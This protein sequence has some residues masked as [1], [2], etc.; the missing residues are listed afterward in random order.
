MKKI[1]CLFMFVLVSL[2]LFGCANSEN[3]VVRDMSLVVNPSVEYVV[4]GLSQVDSVI[5]VEVDPDGC[6]DED[7]IAS[8]FFTSDLV[9]E[10]HYDKNDS[11]V[12][13]GTKAGGSIDIFETEEEAI[14]R[15]EYL[16]KF[17]GKWIFDSGS[18]RVVGTIVIRTSNKL[19]DDVQDELTENI[20]DSLTL[21]D[22]TEDM[23]AA[24]KQEIEKENYEKEKIKV[25]KKYSD[26]INIKYKDAAKFMEKVGF[27]N[28]VTSTESIEYDAEKEGKTVEI[29]IGGN[30]DFKSDDK[31]HPSEEVKI[32]YYKGKKVEVPENWFDLVELHY[33]EVKNKLS[34]AGFTNIVLQAHE[35]DYDASKVFEGSVINIS[36]DD[37]ATFEK[38]DKFYTNVKIRIDYRV[39]LA[40]KEVPP[41]LSND[42][43]QNTTNNA[44]SN[45]NN[46]SNWGNGTNSGN[47][48]TVPQPEQGPILVWVP[49]NGG[50]KYHSYSSCSNMKNPIQVTEDTAKANGFTACA[51]CH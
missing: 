11:I 39:K 22:I 27:T 49:T 34:D 47:S 24:T 26:L 12:E 25:G 46:S 3:E 9:D 31:F 16:Q 38:G 23:V 50:K 36:I 37:N 35:V 28:I 29:T 48:V 33:D 19:E 43:Q 13:R 14:E 20:I 2:F 10:K 41:T 42:N 5:G 40:Q 44:S 15:D 45:T 21:G 17:D 30:K 6:Q 51:R 1:K 4:A 7:G 18:H 8:A 32:H